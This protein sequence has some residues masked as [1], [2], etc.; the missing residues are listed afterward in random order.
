MY[1]TSTLSL[2]RF[3]TLPPGLYKARQGPI[4]RIISS[5][6]NPQRTITHPVIVPNQSRAT[7]HTGRR[8]LRT[9]RPEPV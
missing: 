5:N 2:L 1:S 8:V 9:S 7:Q 6:I 3:V 4:S